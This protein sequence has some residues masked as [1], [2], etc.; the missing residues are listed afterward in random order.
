[1]V[2][3]PSTRKWL[4]PAGMQRGSANAIL[5]IL[6]GLKLPISQDVPLGEVVTRFV[7]FA[8]KNLSARLAA[9]AG[10]LVERGGESL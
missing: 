2:A 6:G 1:M 4:S 3:L 7:D 9:L 10:D 5:A 8:V